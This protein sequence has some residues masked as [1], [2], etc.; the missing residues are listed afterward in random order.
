MDALRT[1]E[2]NT[3]CFVPNPWQPRE[4]EDGEHIKQIALS[5]ATEGLMQAPV[6][7]WIFPDGT[8]A[9][10]MGSADL[11]GSG[12]KVQ[13]AFGHSRLAAFKWLEN[14]FG[15]AG[16]WTKMPVVIRELSDEEMFRQGISENLARKDLSPIE[17]AM[18]M[19]RYRDTFGKTSEEIGK[20]FNLS[21]SG[22]RNKMR[23]LKLPDDIKNLL[24][25]GE[26]REGVAR[27][28]IAISEL[29]ED[30]RLAAEDQDEF[31]KPSDIIEAAKSG[32]NQKAIAEMVS[33]CMGWIGERI[34]NKPKP[35]PLPVAPPQQE[36]REEAPPWVAPVVVRETETH[37][38]EVTRPVEPDPG[39]EYAAKIDAAMVAP[40]DPAEQI[41]DP[42]YTGPAQ[43]PAPEPEPVRAEAKPVT[44]SESTITL[45]L[46]YWPEDGKEGGRTVMAGA[47]ANT[48]L[49][50]MRMYR[51]ANL[52]LGDQLSDLLETLKTQQFGGE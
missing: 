51:E 41:P 22:V 4:N 50:M 49:P 9:R 16:D 38:V 11:T 30:V 35:A 24:R 7:R 46:T 21:D 29:P 3:S 36:K 47:R 32:S 25:Q 23:L 39:R 45:T 42:R 52:N 18:A 43:A 34:L 1:I 8:P 13:L 40:E 48:N 33:R 10:G 37:K 27:E 2:I 17:E 12:L 31:I 28:L 26:M 19:T 6:G 14:E 15:I 5:I 44:W 20:L